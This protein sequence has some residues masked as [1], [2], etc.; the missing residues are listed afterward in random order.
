MHIRL[1]RFAGMLA[2]LGASVLVA[3]APAAAA[4]PRTGASSTQSCQNLSWQ[5]KHLHGQAQVNATELFD[6]YCSG[7]RTRWFTN[8]AQTQ[9]LITPVIPT[10]IGCSL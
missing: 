6:E 3:A 9:V 7:I 4:A 2:A 1:T 8:R 10:S 5:S